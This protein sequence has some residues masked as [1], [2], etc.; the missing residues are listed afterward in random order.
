MSTTHQFGRSLRSLRRGSRRPS[1]HGVAGSRGRPGGRRRARLALIAL[2]VVAML[3]GGWLWLRDSPL[4]AVQRV[5]VT[6][7]RGADAGRIR[8]LLTAAAHGMTT[9]D[10]HAGT[11][12][13]AVSGYPVVK[14]L[15]VETQ[16]PHGLRI[17]V[18][19]QLPVAAV[20]L[21]GHATPVAPDGTVLHDVATNAALPVLTLTAA[22]GG[23]RI[24]DPAARLEL[25]LLAAAPDQMLSRLSGVSDGYWHGLV[26]QVRSG[27]SI[28][29]GSG[30][31]LA[32]KWQAAIA[33]LAAPSTAGATY[34]D[35]TDPRRPA[36]GAGTTVGAP[37]PTVSGTGASGASSTGTPPGA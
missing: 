15:H 34:I 18:T 11:L 3:G 26:A 32:S 13:A 17:A 2:V 37:A 23:T 14:S 22:P 24:T 19:E 33:V 20:M 30:D 31:Q 35:V 1:G 25:R 16:F 12:R 9:L 4:V 6:G 36:A 29:F 7:L 8:A 5:N 10:V 27:P 21:G 28:Y